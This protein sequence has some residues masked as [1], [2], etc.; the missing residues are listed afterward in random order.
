M[1]INEIVMNINVNSMHIY[2]KIMNI[3][4]TFKGNRAQGQRQFS[5]EKRLGY[6]NI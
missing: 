3:N 5:I 2:E 6:E 4:D 1:N